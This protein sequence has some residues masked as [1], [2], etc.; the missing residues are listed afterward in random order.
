MAALFQLLALLWA[1]PGR[2]RAAALQAGVGALLAMAALWSYEATVTLPIAIVLLVWMTTPG[3]PAASR[4][5]QAMVA[6][7]PSLMALAAYSA[8]RWWLVSRPRAD[9]ALYSLDQCTAICGR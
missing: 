4:R 9:A 8:L 3:Q 1:F 6:A 7:I 5:R 2:R